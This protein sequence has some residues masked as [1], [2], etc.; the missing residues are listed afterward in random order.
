MLT[1]IPPLAAGKACSMAEGMEY[2]PSE[3]GTMHSRFAP[4]PGPLPYRLISAKAFE[5]PPVQVMVNGWLRLIVV[6]AE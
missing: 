4:L 1:V 2:C 6:A 3:A 5:S